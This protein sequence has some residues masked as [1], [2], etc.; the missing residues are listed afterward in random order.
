MTADSSPE[1]LRRA[2]E[3]ALRRFASDTHRELNELFTRLGLAGEG[4]SRADRVNR[5]LEPVPD[6]ELLQ[7]ANLLLREPQL[8]GTA[9]ATLQ[10]SVW[11]AEGSFDIPKRTRR[12]L[13]RALSLSD[14]AY[15]PQRFRNALGRWWPLGD[16]DPMQ[17]FAALTGQSSMTGLAALVDR[18]VLRNPGDW[19]IE[20]LFERIGAFDAVGTRFARFL[21]D[22]ASADTVPD[23]KTQHRIA[24]AANTHLRLV[25]FEL[26][27]TGVDEG[28]P[29]FSFASTGQPR[30]RPPK[31]LIFATPQKPDLRLSSSVDNDI[32]IVTNAHTVLVY[33]R[34]IAETGLLWRDLQ[35]WWKDTCQSPSDEQA[36]R[37]LYAKLKASLPSNSPGQHALFDAYY[38]IV[39]DS[40]PD[41][42]ALLPEV[43]LHWDPKTVAQRG[44][45]ALLGHRMDFLL[46][47]PGRV[48]VVLEVDGSHHYNSAAAYAETARGSR[49]LIFAGYEV[50][51]FGTAELQPPGAHERLAGFFGELFRRH[52]V[53]PAP[54]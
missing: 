50:F 27:E 10:D 52:R 14:L 54:H 13:A 43:W 16:D 41:L 18:H 9:R 2:V 42:P 34:P 49:E 19:S 46:L 24:E 23:E 1:P 21:E 4:G 8:T 40:A 44:A 11:M 31:Q 47:L 45:D 51:R 33:D 5:A 30:N 26:R 39:G 25:G 48:R 15:D 12:E 35:A 37:D 7:V 38:R 28:Y 3:D 36:K 32:E 53:A 20:E 6:G 22:L 29:V 17:A